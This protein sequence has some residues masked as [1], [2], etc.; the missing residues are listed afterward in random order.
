MSADNVVSTGSEI[1]A[2]FAQMVN[3]RRIVLFAGLPGVGKSLLIKQLVLMAREVGRVVHLLQW[4]TARP[5][6]ETPQI[7]ARYPEVNGVTHAVIRKAVGL[8]AREGVRM[9][10]ETHSHPSHLLVG[11]TPLIGNRLIELAQVHADRAEPL[12]A[13]DSTL[14]VIPTPSREV[15]RHIE[16]AR[17][18]TFTQPTHA[19]EAADAPPNV[20]QALWEELHRLAVTHGL[21]NAEATEPAPYDP[22][23]YAEIYA[24][25]LKHRHKQTVWIN[26]LFPA[27]GSVYDLGVVASELTAAPVEVERI[28]AHLEQHYTSEQIEDEVARWFER[29]AM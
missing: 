22:Q 2:L 12:L 28:M 25:L 26:E 3:R 13:G 19:R 5:A 15:R 1:Q 17:A 7:L 10:H 23:V 8:W 4:D 11:E 24:R 18:R 21:T 29:T 9:W 6:F 16:A 27:A 20:L 14:F